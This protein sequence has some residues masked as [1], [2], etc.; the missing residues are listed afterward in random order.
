MLGNA[1]QQREVKRR[2]TWR[3]RG[4]SSPAKGG[5]GAGPVVAAGKERR[6]RGGGETEEEGRV[7]GDSSRWEERMAVVAGRHWRR[8]RRPAVAATVTVV[9]VHSSSTGEV[10][11]NGSTQK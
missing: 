8:S 2:D 3:V 6:A 10:G 1:R 7:E 5:G 4:C 9:L 11:W